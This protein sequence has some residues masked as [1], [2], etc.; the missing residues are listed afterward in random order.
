[1]AELTIHVNGKSYIVG[2]EDGEEGHLIALAQRLD[3]KVREIASGAGQLGE[4]RLILLGALVLADDLAQ[5]QARV[6]AAEG[7]AARLQERLAT[8]DD[9]AVSA[10]EAAARRIEA[11]AVG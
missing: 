10:L 2:C 11:A 4:T 9:R 6:T 3:E 1:M 7:A 5:A 8:A